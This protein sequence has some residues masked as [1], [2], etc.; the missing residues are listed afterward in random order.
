MMQIFFQR[1]G[2]SRDLSKLLVNKYSNFI[3]S[4]TNGFCI[5]KEILKQFDENEVLKYELKCY[6]NI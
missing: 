5:D 1:D 4:I 2:L 3:F 6:F